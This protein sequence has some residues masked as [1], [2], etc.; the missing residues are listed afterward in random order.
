MTLRVSESRSEVGSQ[1]TQ[2]EAR[3][4]YARRRADREAT[5]TRQT[6][7]DHRIAD[8]RLVVFLSALILL[9]AANMT[10]R[11]GWYWSLLPLAGFVAMLILHER[12][13]IVGRKMARAVAYYDRGIKRIDGDWPGTGTAG[14]RFALA[15]HP[16]AN[17]L[18]LFGVGSIF[19]RLCTARTRAG[20]DALASWLLGP[21]EPSTIRE[22]QA[23]LA[24]LRPRLDLREDLELIGAEVRE[25]ID[26]ERLASWGRQ[27]PVFT[28]RYPSII[29]FVLSGASLLAMAGWAFTDIGVI[30]FLSVIL[31]QV[32]FGRWQASRVKSVIAPLQSRTH[33]LVLLAELLERF[34]REPFICPALTRLRAALETDG[35]PA[36]KRVARLAK[37]VGLLELQSNQ[38][39]TPLALLLFWSNHFAA[40]IDAW[41]VHTG[42]SIASW[43]KAV[44][45]FEALCAFAAYSWENPDDPFPEI[46]E[47]NTCLDGEGL[48][49]PLIGRTSCVANDVRLGDTLRVLL[50]SGS[51]MSGKSTLLRTVGV[52]TVLAL[53]GATVRAGR[54]RV[55][56]VSVGATLRIQDSLQAGRSRFYAEVSRIK[57]LVDLA[58]GPRPLLFLLDEI[59]HGT[60]SHDRVAGAGA[61]VKGL[62][63][64]GAIGLVTTHDLAL[65]DVAEGLAPRARNVHFEDQL[66]DGTMRF[67]YRMRE[68]IVQH[69]NALALMRAVGLDV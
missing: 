7:L 25:G 28:S 36:S 44:G 41:R 60:N 5:L 8:A 24:E 2:I 22:R 39:F 62:I 52:N 68:G 6:R 65:A 40:A 23:A 34:E 26:P 12:V 33:D 29:A 20:E 61:V 45:D 54:F 47:T 58:A 9:V 46:D 56:V 31:F 50:V 51:N 49:H 3:A 15:E 1:P 42:P 27:P 63:D 66:V 69:S 16:Y 18:D 32:V 35:E 57:Q 13:R 59:F 4:E 38:F 10:G 19:E 48:G 30:P 11:I 21:A 67:D 53:A 37:L 17:D 43:L 55:S 64:R 14:D